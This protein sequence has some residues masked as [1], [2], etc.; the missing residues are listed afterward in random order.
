MR[1]G[2]A[3]GTAIAAALVA[4]TIVGVAQARPSP[5]AAVP[6]LLYHQLGEPSVYSVSVASFRTQLEYLKAHEYRTIT[7]AQ[8]AA[9]LRGGTL[10][11]R[12]PILITFDDG[13]ASEAKASPLLARDGF[14]A[15][16]FVVTGFAT[17]DG[18]WLGWHALRSLRTS[19][20]WEFAFH[21]GAHGH[22]KLHTSCPYFYTCE[23]PHET[24]AAYKSR[25]RH[26][27]ANGEATLTARTPG[28]SRVAWAAPFDAA[29]QFPAE[30][31]DPRI[32]AWVSRFFARRF[33]VVF[34]EERKAGRHRRYR[35]QVTSRTSL[36][37]F[38]AALSDPAFRR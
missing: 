28:W 12:K 2:R 9:W 14:R 6:V 29:G 4:T 3:A 22:V 10:H 11:V 25:V 1:H 19:G 30:S 36:A 21:A 13:I 23:L 17:H 15:V 18:Y 5:P 16:M 8:Y 26:E 35:F 27:V 33:A 38:A 34:V 37:A 20:R 24:F 7:P 31:N 32:P